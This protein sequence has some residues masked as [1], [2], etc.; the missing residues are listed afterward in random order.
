MKYGTDVVSVLDT[1]KCN[2]TLIEAANFDQIEQL[3]SM[4]EEFAEIRLEAINLAQMKIEHQMP[5]VLGGG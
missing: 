3:I 5:F 4:I 2:G 1:S